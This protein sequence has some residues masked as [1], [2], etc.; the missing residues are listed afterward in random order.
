MS[1]RNARKIANVET[2]NVVDVDASNVVD[3]TSNDA[4]SNDDASNNDAT[5]NDDA[6]NDATSNVVAR[7]HNY[8]YVA[9]RCREFGINPK[10][11]RALLRRHTTT[12]NHRWNEQ[13]DDVD[14]LIA[15]HVARRNARTS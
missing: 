7:A 6:S 15:Q 2:S 10:S 11:M 13:R 5:S 9:M 8:S 1:K 4:T 3:T 14:A 12:T